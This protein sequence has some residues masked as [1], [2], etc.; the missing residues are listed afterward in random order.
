MLLSRIGRSTILW[1]KREIYLRSLPRAV[2]FKL[3]LAWA[4]HAPVRGLKAGLSEELA[5]K[6]VKRRGGGKFS[7][8]STKGAQDVHEATPSQGKETGALDDN[9]MAK[10][11]VAELIKNATDRTKPIRR[12][13]ATKL[14]R[15]REAEEK[16]IKLCD[17]TTE[18]HPYPTIPGLLE[19]PRDA[20][21][22]DFKGSP[23]RSTNDANDFIEG[24]RRAAQVELGI[25]KSPQRQN[26]PFTVVAHLS[27]LSPNLLA[28][29]YQNIG[30]VAGM[31]VQMRSRDAEKLAK[32]DLAERLYRV[33]R[34]A[35]E[36][37]PAAC[38]R[39]LS[40]SRTRFLRISLSAELR[41]R[42][43]Q[44]N[45]LLGETGVFQMHPHLEED[46]AAS[47]FKANQHRPFA[48]PSR[49]FTPLSK[50]IINGLTP[51]GQETPRLP[52]YGLFHRIITCIEDNNVTILSAAT[53]SGKTTQI[54]QYILEYYLQ[55]KEHF[56]RPPSVLVTQPRRIAAKTVA[57]RVAT[58]RE[59]MR[60]GGS[61]S[62]G[63]SVRFESK[64]P[65]ALQDGS[66]LFCTAGV[67]L[68]RL[69]KD[70]NLA[71]VTHLILDEVH[72]RD[73]FTDILLLVTR[74]ILK[75]RPDLRLILMS[76]TM[77]AE[78]FVNY[79]REG[80]L[81]VGTVLD[82]EGTNYLVT[83]MYLGEIMQKF[84]IRRDRLSSES[85]EY[86]QTE[87]SLTRTDEN[88]ESA[89]IVEEEA[90]K[91]VPLDLMAELMCS[92]I[93]EKPPGAILAFIPGWEEIT[94][95]HQLLQA[96]LPPGIGGDSIEYHLLH[97]TSPLGAAD[98][99][100]KR[101]PPGVRKVILATNLA[102]SSITIPDVVYVIDSGKQ[103][104]MHYD[105]RLRMNI[106]EP[107]WISKANLRQRLGR[108]GR[109]QPGEYYGMIS[110]ERSRGLPE[111]T[112]PELLRLSLDE[113]CL[114]L[115]A[116]GLTGAAG[117]ILGTAMDPPER[118][119]VRAAIE[120][121]HQI[122]AIDAEERVTPLG[123]LLANLPL[124]PGKLRPFILCLK[125]DHY[126]LH[127]PSLLTPL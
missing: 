12:S 62:V 67:L 72:E 10:H 80:G 69:Q 96:R 93:K 54:P 53:G 89:L 120:R 19:T 71:S 28:E 90:L 125:N 103:K 8:V 74:G 17:P 7:S 30:R 124:H 85:Q 32:L 99:A 87:L 50:H 3:V 46:S 42:I 115:K 102:E 29:P 86:L 98:A 95:L 45:R 1:G 105:Q 112:L 23:F 51:P 113:V 70:P 65:T 24:V 60:P 100:F 121:L 64:P 22:S 27:G 39:V 122:G 14:V 79:F 33:L 114:N 36:F 15:R 104:V 49:G 43:V 127:A 44:T 119:A 16:K 116:M 106:L 55:A 82:V 91:V 107:C 31:G 56:D 108:A 77:S 75:Q 13:Q 52:I 2:A 59:Q 47:T 68:R 25:L 18:W 57:Q 58:E 41:Q 66:I 78:K 48:A 20:L 21:P 35:E 11:H 123:R 6:P 63:Y 88:R 26:K 92:I 81:R 110:R 117:R 111:Q 40:K 37:L 61:Q 97:S 9:S 4:S 118:G 73:V 38:R 126:S 5:S 83:D 34:D 84:N 94:Q 101:P 109:C 76:A